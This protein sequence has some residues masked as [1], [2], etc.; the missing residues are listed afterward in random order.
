M[1]KGASIHVKYSLVFLLSVVLVAGALLSGLYSLRVEVLRNE[2]QAVANQVVSFR[3]WVAGSGMIWVDRLAEG[4]HDFLAE[5]QTEDG[6]TYY[7]KNPALAT[8][9][10]SRIVNNSSQRA[11]FRV[12]SDD[13]RN[14]ENQPDGFEDK[15]IEAL[16]GDKNLAYFEGF[17][18]GDFR[19]AQPIYVK[20]SCLKCHGDAA[21]APPEVIEK[22][23]AQKAFGYKVGEVR[24]I[25]SVRLPDITLAEVLPALANPITLGVLF[26]A[27]LLSYLYVERDIIRR[28]RR[29][30]QNAEDIAKGD[31][32]VSLE[33]RDT[34]GSR[35]EIDHLYGAVNLLR[36]SL[37]VAMRR[38]ER[39]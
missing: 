38:M 14:P 31:M 26:L 9:E 8:R 2:A 5:R 19:Y 24:G 13:Y 32:E 27:F 29:L 17:D 11:T 36:N 7:G 21:D 1:F 30:T 4:F 34:E 20:Q 28:V 39:R 12:T 33:Y 35:N 25:I 10:L 37:K 16:K 3:S 15:A 18:E 6:K 23:G 22:Y